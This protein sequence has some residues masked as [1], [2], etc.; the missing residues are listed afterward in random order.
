MIEKNQFRGHEQVAFIHDKETGL[1]A[2]IAIHD[3]SCGPA[4]GGCR[5]WPYESEMDALDDVLRLS[6][7][8]SFKNAVAGLP[9]GGGKAVIMA[10]S[11]TD[12]SDALFKAFGRF[13]DSLGGKYIAAE[14]VGMTVDDLEMI[15]TETRHVAGLHSGENASGDPSPYTALGVYL[16]IKA[17]VKHKLGRDDVTGLNVAVQGVGHVGYYLCRHLSEAGAKL[18]VCDID[19]EALARVKNEFGATIIGT[20]EIMTV[21]AD[22]LAPCALGATLNEKTIPALKVKIIAG[23]ANN[24]LARD[25][26]GQMLKDHDILYT[27]DYVINAGGIINVAAETAGHYDENW[28]RG[29]VENIYNTLITIFERADTEDRPTNII[30]DELAVEIM[31]KARAVKDNIKAA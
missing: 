8:M 23:A 17:A 7:G 18:I 15:G 28:V 2:F 12:K 30:A 27:P 16:G 19:E 5:M 26:H 14:D 3:T 1:K 21:E 9:L 6:R 10:N 24:Q 22:I 4:A 25:M 13:V 20:D 31:E 11:K 29:K